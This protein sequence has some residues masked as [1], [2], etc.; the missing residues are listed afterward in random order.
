MQA[1][2]RVD[3]RVAVHVYDSCSQLSTMSINNLDTMREVFIL[4]S[5]FNLD[6]Q[7][8]LEKHV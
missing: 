7:A 3:A 5:R 4:D 8:I 2:Q 1:W 6:N